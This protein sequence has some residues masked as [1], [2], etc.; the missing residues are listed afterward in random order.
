[1][2][3]DPTVV[4]RAALAHAI[5]QAQQ[6]E[7]WREF[8][9]TPEGRADFVQGAIAWIVEKWPVPRECPHCHTTEWE[10]GTPFELRTGGD[11][12]LTPHFP[13]MC[14]NCGNTVLINAVRAGLVPEPEE[15]AK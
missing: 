5:R 15:E 3:D 9:E 12:S 7:Q 11:A 2:A 14:S 1:M 4:R 6:R 10:V 8:L 13:V